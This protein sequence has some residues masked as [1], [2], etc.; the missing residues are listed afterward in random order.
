[1]NAQKILT[2]KNDSIDYLSNLHDIF[3]QMKKHNNEYVILLK[4]KKPVGIYTN[5]DIFD[6]IKSNIHADFI[7]NINYAK[8]P[9]VFLSSTKLEHIYS[10]IVNFNINLFVF[11]D[12]LG[13]YSGTLSSTE[14]IYHLKKYQFQKNKSIQD[15]YLKNCI[16]IS[17]NLN[18][19]QAYDMLSNNHTSTILIG[20]KNNVK[21]I[22]NTQNLLNYIDFD[23]SC[24][25]KLKQLSPINALHVN[26]DDELCEIAQNMINLNQNESIV[27]Y[28]NE[29][30]SLHVKQILEALSQQSLLDIKTNLNHSVLDKLNIAVFEVFKSQN[31]YILG[32]LNQ[33][34]KSYFHYEKFQSIQNFLSKEQWD[35][36]NEKINS[37]EIIEDCTI[38]INGISK[39]LRVMYFYQ[40]NFPIMQLL[41][42]NSKIDTNLLK[43]N[44]KDNELKFYKQIFNQNI[45][46]IAYVSKELK[47]INA[48]PF[49]EKYLGYSQNELVGLSVKDIL[50]EDEWEKVQNDYKYLQKNNKLL[51]TTT[52]NYLT[53]NKSI[54]K[55]IVAL[56]TILDNKNQIEYFVCFIESY[57]KQY[58]AIRK[59]KQ[60]K[61]ILKSVFDTADNPI[62]FKDAHL[63]Y[64]AVNKAFVDA[65]GI[66]EDDILGK[67]DF[68]IFSKEVASLHLKENTSLIKSRQS[69]VF[70]REYKLKNGQKLSCEVKIKPVFDE[71]DKFFGIVGS[72][73]DL[74]LK[75]EID[76]RKKL[77][78]SVFNYSEEGMVITDADQKIIAVNQAFENITGYS[79]SEIIGQCPNI[80]A[81]HE[82]SNSFYEKMWHDINTKDSWRGEIIN[83]RKSGEKYPELLTI[84]VIKDQSENVKNYLGIF[85]DITNLRKNQNKLEYLAHHDL[86]TGLS[87]KLSLEYAINECISYKPKQKL[88]LLFCDLDHFKEINDTYGHSIG[89]SVLVQ[90]SKRLLKLLSTH[91]V[92]ARIS[93][94]EF[95]ILLQ[96]LKSQ[97]NLKDK[98]DEIF[99]IFKYP[100]I[101]N[102]K[103]FNITCSVGASVY[104]KDGQ[105]LESLLKNADLALYEAKK[106]GR[107]TYCIYDTKFTDM[108]LKKIQV[109]SDIRRGMSENEFFLLYQ[110]QININTNKIVAAEALL[111]WNHPDKGVVLPGE[112]IR[113]A[114]EN[115]LIIPL[116]RFVIVQACK[117]IKKWLQCG[118]NLQNF[119]VAINVS[120]VQLAH[121][122]LYSTIIEATNQVG[123]NPKYLELEL[124]E[125]SIMQNPNVSINLFEK[126]R[127]IG[128]NIS[129][130]DFGTGYSSLSYLKKFSVN[131]I[132]IDRSF[133]QD[134]PHDKDDIAITKAVL[135]MGKSMELDVVAEGIEDVEQRDF[136][137][138]QGCKKAQ[139]F[140]YAKPIS[141][142]EL[143]D[144]FLLN[145]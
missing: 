88:G 118:I 44:Q 17:E 42:L 8:T 33:C 85:S 50:Q 6:F 113:L 19:A 21:G 23:K 108:L 2:N 97:K 32:W 27:S 121:D 104:P 64:K 125:T 56:G 9:I 40:N 91:D 127:E 96:D 12:N 115:Q 5:L 100:F 73:T 142:N 102:E 66:S 69:T 134:L 80:L 55:G 87:N 39:I 106:S 86:L 89:D 101:I 1:M 130:D 16:Y 68:D 135:A 45:M 140:F 111:R 70:S 10:I 138:Q 144:K 49:L 7:P 136:L 25:T 54:K 3:H 81:S 38:N 139:G 18:V 120:A 119:K 24:L 84:S 58:N 14:I 63:K 122:D 36:I 28:K 61:N 60:Q 31:E 133:I 53:K 59:Q 43:H 112:F 71:N 132:K 98:I 48:N 35:E 117:D 41:I 51:R 77:I 46:G 131:Q 65:L 78:Q 15:I 83:K 107:N 67:S 110:P 13:Q 109:L 4:D 30:Y 94:D 52:R 82:H 95:V 26:Y 79:Q 116:G 74:T 92:L 11:V 57:E 129:I 114:E 137:I 126:L 47:I 37:Q 124:T 123:I 34:A 20:S 76:E 103:I 105:N 90:V 143:V 62:F 72:A 99:K 128:I 145:M 141:A 22:F 93:G 29:C 75:N